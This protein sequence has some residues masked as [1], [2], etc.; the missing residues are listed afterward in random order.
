MRLVRTALIV[1]FPPG[2]GNLLM[3]HKGVPR[4]LSFWILAMVFSRLFFI[5]LLH[6]LRCI[7]RFIVLD[8]TT[9]IRILKDVKGI[10]DYTKCKDEDVLKFI[11]MTWDKM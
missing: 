2:Y 6:T 4:S 3:L 10:V 5:H 8:T 11:I 7:D 9:G 1:F